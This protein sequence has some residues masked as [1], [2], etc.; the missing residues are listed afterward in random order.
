[1]MT[2]GLARE[3]ARYDINV[4]ALCP[5][6][7]ETEINDFW[8]KTEGGQ[9]QIKQLPAPQAGGAERSGR[10]Y[11]IAGRTIGQRHYRHDADG[12]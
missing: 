12:R 11:F 9:K 5:G 2:R 10:S 8:W 4:N 1:M 6:Y 3:W 7:I